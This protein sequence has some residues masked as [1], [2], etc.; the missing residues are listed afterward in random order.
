MLITNLQVD[1]IDHLRHGILHR[2]GELRICRDDLA[3]DRSGGCLEQFQELMPG[4]IMPHA[5]AEC[6]FDIC[7]RSRDKFAEAAV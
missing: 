4:N 3:A 1:V 6:E 5:D 7:G 2:I